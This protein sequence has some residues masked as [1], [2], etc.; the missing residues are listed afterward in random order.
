MYIGI[1]VALCQELYC[2]EMTHVIMK[3]D[4]SQYQWAA[5][6]R[7]RT[8]DGLV[9]VLRPKTQETGIST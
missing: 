6:W 9:L 1:Y 4:K 8:A 3:G 7:P 5:P 2:N